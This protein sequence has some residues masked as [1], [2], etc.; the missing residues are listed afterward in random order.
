MDSHDPWLG[1]GEPRPER[2]PFEAQPPNEST[3]ASRAFDDRWSENYREPGPGRAWQVLL[4]G[5]VVFGLATLAVVAW[6]VVQRRMAADR[7]PPHVEES[8]DEKF[9]QAAEAFS[10]GPIDGVVPPDHPDHRELKRIHALFEALAAVLQARDVAE[11]EKLFDAER[12]WQEVRRQAAG[13]QLTAQ[14]D[15]GGR[16]GFRH[17][18]FQ[19]FATTPAGLAHA[20]FEVRNCRFDDHG[21]QAVVYVRYWNEAGD[22]GKSR[23]WLTRRGEQWLVYDLEELTISA[24]MTTINAMALSLVARGRPLQFDPMILTQ[25]LQAVSEEDWHTVETL[26]ERLDFSQ[27]PEPMQAIRWMLQAA[28]DLGYE[29]FEQVLEACDEAEALHPDMP[30]LNLQRAAALNGLGR[31]DEAREYAQKYLDLLGADGVAFNHLGNALFGLGRPKEAIEAYRR[32]LDDEPNLHDSLL[33]LA[34]LLPEDQQAEIAERF[35]RFREP[36][37]WFDRLCADLMAHGNDAAV[38]ALAAAYAAIRPDDPDIAYYGAWVLLHREAYEAAAEKVSSAFQAVQGRHDEPAFVNLY[39]DAMAGAGRMLDGYRN[40]PDPD[41]AFDYLAS[42]ALGEQRA[43]DLK[44]LL[45]VHGEAQPDAPW[46]AY[47]AGGL[48]QFEGD[49]QTAIDCYR[50]GWQANRNTDDP[51]DYTAEAYREELIGAMYLAG[52]PFHAYAEVE[53]RRAAFTAVASR[54]EADDDTNGLAALLD[55]HR[56]AEPDDPALDL[57]NVRLAFMTKEYA[58]VLQAIDGLR[59]AS[60]DRRQVFEDWRWWIDDVLVRSHIHL[61]RLDEALAVARDA[62]ARH[63]NPRFH[64]LA[65][66]ARGDVTETLT[67]LDRCAEQGHWIDFFYFDDIIGP[68]LRSDAF[69]PVRE[70]YPEPDWEEEPEP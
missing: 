8:A 25:V 23:W 57:W 1:Y 10:G 53:P 45:A 39:L 51:E 18:L 58:S 68:A 70:K 36:E 28:V 38:E 64:V 27:L 26:L 17:G 49:W 63:E 19:G 4:V 15:R 69:A 52:Q 65:Y 22:S 2:R 44:A 5:V 40:A 66:A 56:R 46:L 13:V 20:R 6:H 37:Q 33:S 21:K 60:G 30:V 7:L 31:F 62:A 55:L 35:A 34:Y 67:W 59:R 43:D 14:Q 47:Y 24:R 54:F 11:L 42:A 61:G 9:R 48:A 3:P 16:M 29:R 12:M 50:A 41:Y 32:A